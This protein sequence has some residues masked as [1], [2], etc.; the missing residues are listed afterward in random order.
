M[1]DGRASRAAR[2]GKAPP[3]RL[4]AAEFEATPEFRHFRTVMRRVVAVPKAELDA[5][6][7]ASK[8]GRKPKR[9]RSRS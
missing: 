8:E 5:M 2:A 9:R 3:R 6:V 7:K 4:M 1:A